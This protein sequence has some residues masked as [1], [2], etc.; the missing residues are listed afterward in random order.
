[1]SYRDSFVIWEEY[2]LCRAKSV[3]VKELR[4]KFKDN[5]ELREKL[6]NELLGLL[7]RHISLLSELLEK[8]PR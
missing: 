7:E 4:E 1:M 2:L 6:R 5:T 3:E 8:T